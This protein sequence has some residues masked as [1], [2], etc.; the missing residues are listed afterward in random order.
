MLHRRESNVMEENLVDGMMKEPEWWVKSLMASRN[1]LLIRLRQVVE[2]ID[3][4]DWER[5]KDLR[6]VIDGGLK[7]YEDFQTSYNTCNGF[8]GTSAEG[9]TYYGSTN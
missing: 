5:L 4:E 6:P 8:K 2:A 7:G 3:N 9:V 1:W